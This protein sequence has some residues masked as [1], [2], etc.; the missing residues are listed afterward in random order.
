MKRNPAHSQQPVCHWR[1][2]LEKRKKNYSSWEI[3]LVFELGNKQ[4]K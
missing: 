4:Y 1:V 2:R 3:S